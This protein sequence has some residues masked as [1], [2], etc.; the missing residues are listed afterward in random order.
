M[1][2]PADI[3]QIK[4]MEIK[5]RITKLLDPRFSKTLVKSSV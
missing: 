4:H 3:M 1:F 2:I 5:E